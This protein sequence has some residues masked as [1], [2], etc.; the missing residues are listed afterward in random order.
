M[1]RLFFLHVPGCPACGKMKPVMKKVAETRKDVNVFA[2]DLSV[3]TW[4]LDWSPSVTPTLV[5]VD[6]YGARPRMVE[7]Y[8]PYSQVVN[9]IDQK[10]TQT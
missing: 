1:K 7:G 4:D 6:H 8:A 9:W 3:V 2:V 5:I 10:W